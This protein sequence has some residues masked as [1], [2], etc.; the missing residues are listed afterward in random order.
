MI[1]AFTPLIFVKVLWAGGSTY[2]LCTSLMNKHW[3]RDKEEIPIEQ[4]VG[5]SERGNK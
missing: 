2:R 5:V 1:V 3:R 4:R